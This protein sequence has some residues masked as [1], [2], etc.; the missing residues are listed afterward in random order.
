MCPTYKDEASV[1]ADF[2]R[3]RQILQEIATRKGVSYEQALEEI[4]AEQ[5]TEE[6]KGWVEWEKKHGIKLSQGHF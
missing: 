4:Q 3:G 6:E 1:E 5:V 2:E